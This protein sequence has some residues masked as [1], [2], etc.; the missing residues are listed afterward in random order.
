MG[1]LQLLIPAKAGTQAASPRHESEFSFCP[2]FR[3]GER[4]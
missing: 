3:R 1:R 4:V 2:G